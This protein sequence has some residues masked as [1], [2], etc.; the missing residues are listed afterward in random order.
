MKENPSS[1]RSKKWIETALL[2]L[3]HNTPY[4]KINISEICRRADL[5]RPTF[6]Q[7]FSSKDDVIV[8]Y[9]DSLFAGFLVEIDKENIVSLHGMTIQFFEFWK[10]RRSFVLLLEKNGLFDLLGKQFVAYLNILF[11]KFPL[12][13]KAISGRQRVYAHAFLSGGLIELLRKWIAHDCKEDTTRLADF[14]EALFT[15]GWK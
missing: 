1:I 15:D 2:E 5:T 8:R 12:E 7:H 6:Y 10:H 9:L 11:I 4:S 13:T 3:M 14:V